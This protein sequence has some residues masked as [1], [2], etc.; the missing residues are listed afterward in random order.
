M[1]KNSIKLLICI[2]IPFFLS[3]LF[4]TCDYNDVIMIYAI[5]TLIGLLLPEIDKINKN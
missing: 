2:L 5:G 4:Y 1:I 3:K